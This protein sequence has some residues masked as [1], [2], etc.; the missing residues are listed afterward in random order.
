MEKK[1]YID[2]EYKLIN[3]I[4]MMEF[5]NHHFAFIIAISDSV[6]NYQWI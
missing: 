4:K 6:K 2:V 5:E 3:V 1:L